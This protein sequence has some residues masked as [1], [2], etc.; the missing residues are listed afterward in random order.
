M[1]TCLNSPPLRACV[2]TQL[3]SDAIYMRGPLEPHYKPHL[4][5]PLNELFKSGDTLLITDPGVP[6]ALRVVVEFEGGDPV[7]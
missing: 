3:G 1:P 4:D 5:M 6:T 7:D 2:C